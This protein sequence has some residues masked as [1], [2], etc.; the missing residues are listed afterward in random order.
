MTHYFW[1]KTYA[2]NEVFSCNKRTVQPV[3]VFFNVKLFTEAAI[4]GETSFK[5]NMFNYSWTK[6]GFRDQCF[7]HIVA[8]FGR[9]QPGFQAVAARDFFVSSGIT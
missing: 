5:Q 9:T 3:H 7:F 2:A 1:S 8:N 6:V 4:R